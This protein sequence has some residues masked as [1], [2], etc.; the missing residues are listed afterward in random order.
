M[1]T[2]AF[3]LHFHLNRTRRFERKKNRG[4]PARRVS[5]AFQTNLQLCK[6]TFVFRKTFWHWALVA[7]RACYSWE[8]VSLLGIF[9]LFGVTNISGKSFLQYTAASC[10]P[11][12]PQSIHT[13]GL[14]SDVVFV[15]ILFFGHWFGRFGIRTSARLSIPRKQYLII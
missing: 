4:A 3:G 8:F 12:C 1:Y 2:E 15:V 10:R 7:W 5:N 11:L 14:A 13:F 6:R 9:Q